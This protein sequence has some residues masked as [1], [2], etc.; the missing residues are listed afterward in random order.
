[1]R[2]VLAIALG[3]G[4][5]SAATANVAYI[6]QG[7]RTC[8]ELQLAAQQGDLPFRISFGQWAMG[9]WS[10]QNATSVITSDLYRDLSEI[11]TELEAF[12]LVNAACDGHPTDFAQFAALKVYLSH[13]TS[14]YSEDF[15][16]NGK[17]LGN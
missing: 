5:A 13:P 4:S 15:S 17:D 6:G 9:F 10:G 7:G 11:E 2:T 16:N 1:M 12:D 8:A 3:L 14:R